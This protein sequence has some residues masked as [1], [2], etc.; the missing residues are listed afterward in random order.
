M[1]LVTEAVARRMTS[2]EDHDAYMCGP[3]PM[4]DAAVPL[5]IERGGQ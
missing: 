3:P 2:L 5:L 1:G 4:I